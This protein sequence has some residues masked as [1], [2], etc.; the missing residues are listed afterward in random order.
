MP[1]QCWANLN[2]QASTPRTKESWVKGFEP[3][4]CFSSLRTSIEYYSQG[5]RTNKQLFNRYNGTRNSNFKLT[6]TSKVNFNQYDN[7]FCENTQPRSRS[8]DI[9][10]VFLDTVPVVIDS[11]LERSKNKNRHVYIYYI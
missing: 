11:T 3:T 6:D 2:C 7:A 9:S 8:L 5:P 4:K 10:I 1:S